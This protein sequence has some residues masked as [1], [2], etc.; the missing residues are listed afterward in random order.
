MPDMAA[1]GR[2]QQ[3]LLAAYTQDPT[4]FVELYGRFDR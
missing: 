3:P 2:T 4:G 1:G